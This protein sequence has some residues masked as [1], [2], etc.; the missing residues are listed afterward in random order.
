MLKDLIIPGIGTFFGLGATLMALAAP[1]YFANAPTWV[2][3]W[4]FWI[5][6]IIMALMVI[7]AGI[8]P[9]GWHVA[10]WSSYPRQYWI[11]T[12]GIS[13]NLAKLLSL[14]D[15]VRSQNKS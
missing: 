3:H 2:W 9:L 5:G 7:D 12:F 10:A 14:K 6:I 1:L 11:V 4:L 15:T 13:C 8:P